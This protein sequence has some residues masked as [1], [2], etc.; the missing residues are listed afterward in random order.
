MKLSGRDAKAFFRHPDTSKGGLLIYGSDAMRVALARQKVVQ[1][2]AG[3]NAEN[4]MRLTRISGGDLRKDETLAGDAMRAQGFFPG[5]RLVLVEDATDANCAA[6]LLALDSWQ[7]DDGS[8]VVTAGSL[9]TRSSLRKTFEA[10]KNA[11]AAPVFDDPLDR[12]EIEDIANAAGLGE[13][14]REAWQDIETLAHSLDPGDF[15]QTVEKVSLYTHDKATPVSSEDIAAVA[16][17]ST[18]AQMDDVLHS[19]AE[20]KPGDIGPIIRKLSAQ[21]VQPVALCIAATRHFRTLLAAATDPSGVSSGLA[22][23]RPP[24]F[25]P[26]R[27][28]MARQ[29]NSWGTRNLQNAVELLLDTDLKLRSNAPV[30]SMPLLER[31]LIRLAMMGQR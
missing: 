9:T 4:E 19:V 5:P 1:A 24:V 28:R 7:P 31:T 20:A 15:R 2:W 12:A 25:G 30:P 8:L 3:D 26:R 13:L 6:L 22:R 17:Q 29:A 18:E 11:F 21:G 10:H 14:S 16:P 27:D 23:Q